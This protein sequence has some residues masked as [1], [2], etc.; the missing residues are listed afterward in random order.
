MKKVA[1]LSL[2]VLGFCFSC[3]EEPSKRSVHCSDEVPV[4]EMCL[5]HFERWFY[6]SSANTCTKKAYSGCTEYGFATEQECLECE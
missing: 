1:F 4:D 3:T 6:D 5:A 2:V